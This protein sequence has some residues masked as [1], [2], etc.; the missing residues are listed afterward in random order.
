MDKTRIGKTTP[1]GGTTQRGCNPSAFVAA[2]AF[3]LGAPSKALR[4][5]K[6]NSQTPTSH[7][8]DDGSKEMTKNQKRRARRKRAKRRGAERAYEIV[9]AERAR[10]NKHRIPKQ[11]QPP[12]E[13]FQRPVTYEPDYQ[14]S[15][16]STILLSYKPKPQRVKKP[17]RVDGQ[18]YLGQGRSKK[19]ARIEAAATALRSFI[20]FKDGAVLTPLKP[21]CNLDFTSDEHLDNGTGIDIDKMS[22]TELILYVGSIVKKAKLKAKLCS[23]KNSSTD[24]LLENIK[25]SMQSKYSHF[26]FVF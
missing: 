2:G 17:R 20:Q 18:K 22:Q 24:L 19:I 23:S 11:L 6:E 26:K 8:D 21:A 9:I 1:D 10:L 25:L 16:I 4:F 15:N 14:Y 3:G 5:E 13:R 12:P 7:N